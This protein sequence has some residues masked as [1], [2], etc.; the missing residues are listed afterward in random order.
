[1]KAAHLSSGNLLGHVLGGHVVQDEVGLWRLASRRVGAF[2]VGAQVGD[3]AFVPFLIDAVA[4]LGIEGQRPV[5]ALQ[6]V[7]GEYPD[8]RPVGLALLP[9]A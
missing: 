4:L 7:Q 1:M 8:P 6:H 5:A 9:M 2:E 3:R